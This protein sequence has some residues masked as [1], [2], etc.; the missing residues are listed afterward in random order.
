MGNYKVHFGCACMKKPN[1]HPVWTLIE[2]DGPK[3][4][5]CDNKPFLATR[6]PLGLLIVFLQPEAVTTAHLLMA[7]VGVSEL[8]TMSG[9]HHVAAALTDGPVENHGS[10][11]DEPE[12]VII[13]EYR[14]PHPDFRPTSFTSCYDFRQTPLPILLAEYVSSTFSPVTADV[15]TNCKPCL[16]ANSYAS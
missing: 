5:E 10:R 9:V 12:E 11:M 13:A 8:Q 6:I 14:E 1:L 2:T 7:V 3:Q 16:C 15:S 4:Q